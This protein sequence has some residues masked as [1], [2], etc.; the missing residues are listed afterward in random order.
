MSALDSLETYIRSGEFGREAIIFV[1]HNGFRTIPVFYETP[2]DFFELSIRSFSLVDLREDATDRLRAVTELLKE[3]SPELMNIA[4]FQFRGL[5]YQQLA[6]LHSLS[7]VPHTWRAPLIDKETQTGEVHYAD[8]V[9]GLGGSLRRELAT[10]LNSEFGKAAFTEEF[11]VLASFVAG[12][13]SHRIELFPIA[14][15]LRNNSKTVAFRH[16]VANLQVILRDQRDLPRIQEAQKELSAVVADLRRELGLQPEPAG[17]HQALTIKVG[18]P[19]T[20]SA[21]L[22]LSVPVKTPLWLRRVFHRR[23]HLVFLRDLMRRSVS[24]PP[25]AVAMQRMPA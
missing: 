16:W 4:T 11:P 23:S 17:H 2:A 5:F 9:V 3:I 22:P 15:E 10:R 19:G 25:F 18:I 20:A 7:Y 6:N 13:A 21:E 24:L 1:E 8:Y 12:Q 14:V